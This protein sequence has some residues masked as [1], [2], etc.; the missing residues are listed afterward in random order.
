MVGWIQCQESP[1]KDHYYYVN[2]YVLPELR[3]GG[4]LIYGVIEV[5]RLQTEA[6]G[7]KTISVYETA[8]DNEGMFHFMRDRLETYRTWMDMKFRSEK[9]L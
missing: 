4:W 8:A 5:C 7:P 3:R 2:G 1:L 6:F 9:S